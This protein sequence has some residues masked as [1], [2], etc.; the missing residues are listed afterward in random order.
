MKIVERKNVFL[1]RSGI[2]LKGMRLIDETIH[3]YKGKRN[4]FWMY[5]LYHFVF[6]K[7]IRLKGKFFVIH[8]HWCPGYFHWITEALPRLLA[9]SSHLDGHILVLP[10]S[11]K[12]S[13]Y[14]SIKPIYYGEV[15]WIPQN[16]DLLI[17]SLLI[18]ENP[19]FSGFYEKDLIFHLREIY[20]QGSLNFSSLPKTSKL[21]ISRSKAKQR[22]VVNEASVVSFL[23]ELGF[24]TVNF[25]EFTFWE[26]V[27]LMKQTDILVSIHGAGLTN[28][29]FMKEGSRVI[30]LQKDL[31][32]TD[33]QADV[34]YKD[35][36]E[37]LNVKY[38]VLYCRPVH[39]DESHYKADIVVNLEKLKGL[40]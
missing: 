21:Y 5:A 16:R 3:L 1:T 33:E 22:K 9:V 40:L 7:K 39:P 17:E 20:T 25:E 35:F 34:L 26:Q 4:H 36:A 32:R 11:F 12:G 24:E 28:L 15:Y 29:L 18:P 27:A 6:R 38:D 37:L 30:E 2:G 14:E 19:P 13:I 31:L 8:N 10:E 23:K